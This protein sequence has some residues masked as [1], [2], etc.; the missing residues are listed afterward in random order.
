M[1]RACQLGRST[2][3]YAA[4]HMSTL[5]APPDYAGRSLVN[6]VAE[7]EHR[8]STTA[9]AP[10]LTPEL[11]AGIP[12]ASTYILVLM[13]G[14]GTRQLDH[15]LAA[16][17]RDALAGS[18]AAPFPSTTT[19]SLATIATGTPP[20]QHGLLS[21]MLY[22]P[23]HGVFNALKW[24]GKHGSQV[25]HP[26]ETFLPRPNL[27]ERLADSGIEP[28]TVQPGHFRTTPLSRALYRN[29]RFEAI[30]SHDEAAAAA[31]DLAATP[32]RLIFLYLGDVDFAAHLFGQSS[33]PYDDAVRVVA[34][35]WD[36]IVLRL[37]EHAAMVGTA[38]HGH[39]D[40]AAGDKYM[41]TSNEVAGVDVYGDP[42]A[43][44]LRGDRAEEIAAGLPGEW[45]PLEKARAWWGPG[46]EHPEFAERAPSG[47][48]LADPGMVLIPGHMDRR[49]I[50]YHGGLDPDELEIPI[51][52][53]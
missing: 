53:A 52:I 22:M 36:T 11:A 16:T 31:L 23:E 1:A 30:W 37:P 50:G 20:R 7:L 28:I 34:R 27:W 45:V 49:L 29:C 4:D 39:I 46:P 21:H 8:L 13:D 41:V 3:G 10:R 14:L 15:R 6:L 24:I 2:P 18:I 47:V 25:R 19:V 26:M 17:F 33:Q 48:L 38:D 5:H 51:L 40:Y 9:V 32:G 35:V 44:L 12:D 43:L 42:R